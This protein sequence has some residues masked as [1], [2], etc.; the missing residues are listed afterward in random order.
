LLAIYKTVEYFNQPFAKQVIID[1]GIARYRVFDTLA[2][3]LGSDGDEFRNNGQN[4]LVG[5]A[6]VYLATN[7]PSQFA[8]ALRFNDLELWNGK[9]DT[10]E[11]RESIG[12]WNKRDL[13]WKSSAQFKRIT[14]A[15]RG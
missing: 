11:F 7:S 15:K 3:W 8:E 2:M 12:E 6:N 4:I 9:F 13:A 10:A 14:G 1:L 5:L